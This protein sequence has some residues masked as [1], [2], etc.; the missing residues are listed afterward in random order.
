MNHRHDYLTLKFE[1]EN[2]KVAL[3]LPTLLA[4]MWSGIPLNVT[5]GEHE[6][7]TYAD[8]RQLLIDQYVVHPQKA[9]VGELLRLAHSVQTAERHLMNRHG[10]G[11]IAG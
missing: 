4:G 9:E 3:E 7:P 1:W 5:K 11:L 10:E 8:A 2:V 6:P